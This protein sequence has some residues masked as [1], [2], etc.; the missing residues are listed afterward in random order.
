MKFLYVAEIAPYMD[1]GQLI[2]PGGGEAHGFFL[3]SELAKRGHD[4]KIIT[5]KWKNTPKEESISGVKIVRYGNYAPWYNGSKILALKN[6]ILNTIEC[7]RTLQTLIKKDKP[8]FII[9]PMTFAFPRAMLLSKIHHIPLIAEVHDVYEMPL[10][11]QHYRKDYGWLVYPGALFVW[12]YNNLPAYADLVETVSEQ[13]IDPMV[14]K[15]GIRK[16]RI[17]VTGNGINFKKVG[18]FKKEEL[19]AILGRLV[20]YKRVDKAIK[21]FKSVKKRNPSVRL[22]I[23][24]DGP[25]R[26]KL[27]LLSEDGIEFL[28]YISEDKKIA[29]LER[30]KIV[31][32]CSEF[33]GFGIVPIE[34]LAYEAIPVLSDIPA[35]REV[36]NTHGFL[37]E[38]IGECT[39]AICDLLQNEG[40]R[41]I[42]A[43]EG[44]KYVKSQYSWESVCD[45]FLL[46]V[47]KDKKT[48]KT[49]FELDLAFIPPTIHENNC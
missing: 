34:A 8:D 2:V 22:V 43:K 18:N 11:L 4:V 48:A 39:A 19:I 42:L 38:N 45:R 30:S 10:Y 36:I 41:R 37:S 29:L 49:E 16:E 12:L 1:K 47:N 35:H 3:C 28:G 14:K 13:N 46:M 31:I 21:I 24:G 9:S 25:E 23:A 5:G 17:F 6:L 7:T 15:Y 33:E 40:E 32:S 27:E 20:S 44:S 26:K